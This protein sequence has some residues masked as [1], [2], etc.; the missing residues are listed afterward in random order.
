MEMAEALYKELESQGYQD[1]CFSKRLSETEKKE[2]FANI[3][4][5]VANLD[6]LI[7]TPVMTCRPNASLETYLYNTSRHNVSRND[8]VSLLTDHL[9][10]CGYNINIAEDCPSIDS[11]LTENNESKELLLQ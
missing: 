5:V 9:S 11:K 2:I 1:K 10:E 3:N 4:N 6:Y 7:A 8:F